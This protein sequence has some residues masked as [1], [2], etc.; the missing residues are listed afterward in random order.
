MYNYSSRTTASTASTE[1]RGFKTSVDATVYVS[2]VGD[3]VFDVQF[4]GVNTR[5]H[6]FYSSHDQK[7]SKAFR[8]S[9]STV[10]YESD[11]V[12]EVSNMKKA[13][14]ETLQVRLEER[15]TAVSSF[16][17][18]GLKYSKKQLRDGSIEITEVINNDDIIEFSPAATA[19][20]GDFKM[21]SVRQFTVK[22]GLVKKSLDDVSV[23]FSSVAVDS[24][25]GSK[26]DMEMLTATRAQLTLNKIVPA[27]PIL[28]MT[29]GSVKD[30]LMAKPTSKVC[31]IL[32]TY[33]PLPAKFP[34]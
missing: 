13:I 23:R 2:C 32:L 33:R 4:E 14:V 7:F 22:D 11:E 25:D 27:R 34:V 17:L 26:S 28:P 16:G 10:M 29:R 21:E 8:F 1:S 3:G 31:N 12:P 20:D 18:H 9:G 19:R 24:F 30:S 6:T 5:A 15:E